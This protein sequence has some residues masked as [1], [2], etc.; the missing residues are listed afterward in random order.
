M[1][2]SWVKLLGKYVDADKKNKSYFK[3][4]GGRFFNV[5]KTGCICG[6]QSWLHHSPRKDLFKNTGAHS[7]QKIRIGKGP[8]YW[9]FF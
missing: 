7:P 5:L 2:S 9:D 1:L 3:G 8:E 6:F 4:G